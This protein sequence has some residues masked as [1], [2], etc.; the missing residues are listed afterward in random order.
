MTA[1]ELVKI[2]RISMKMM[3]KAGIKVED[4][5]FVAMYEEY[6]VMRRDRL[7]YRY[8]IACLSEK[9]HISESSVRRVIKRLSNEV[10]V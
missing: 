5:E 7:K 6:Q 8:V 9:Y 2:N 4:C 10:K 1:H 3:S